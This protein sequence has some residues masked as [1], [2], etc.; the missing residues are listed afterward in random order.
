MKYNISNTT[1]TIGSTT[2]GQVVR[3]ITSISNVSGYKIHLNENFK[4]T[5]G[6]GDYTNPYILEYN[7]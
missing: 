4:I 3:Y 6:T 5:I 7:N 2:I 1:K